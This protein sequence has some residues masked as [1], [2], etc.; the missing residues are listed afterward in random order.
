MAEQFAKAAVQKVETD[1]EVDIEELKQHKYLFCAENEDILHQ[2]SQYLPE[3]IYVSNT[4][5]NF[6]NVKVDAVVIP[7]KFISHG[8]YYKVKNLLNVPLIHCNGNSSKTIL[9]EIQN[10]MSRKET[11]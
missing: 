7:T 4:T 11:A 5:T 9:C 3:S 10:E 6:K 2:L 1:C 8:M